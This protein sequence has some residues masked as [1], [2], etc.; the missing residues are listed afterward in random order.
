VNSSAHDWDRALEDL[1]AEQVAE[2]VAPTAREF[3]GTPDVPPYKETAVL[4]L[5]VGD[6]RLLAAFLKGPRVA[7]RTLAAGGMG[8]AVLD[9][10]AE[11]AALAAARTASSTLRGVPVFLLRRG[12]TKDPAG[13]DIQGYLWV[14]GVVRQRVPAGL[15]LARAPQLLEDLLIDPEA[16]EVALAE[17]VSVEELSP[18]DAIAI[19]GRNLRRSKRKRETETDSP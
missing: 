19:I 9:D 13:A 3:G 7:A 16:A 17:A 14:D 6:K 4:V 10:P 8:F 12:P 2:D 5:G 15:A 1:L 18:A 11:E